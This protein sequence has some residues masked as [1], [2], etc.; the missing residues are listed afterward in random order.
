MTEFA[1]PGWPR[2]RRSLANAPFEGPREHWRA[3]TVPV[4]WVLADFGTGEPEWTVFHRGVRPSVRLCQVCGLPLRWTII[5]GSVP[6]GGDTRLTS[7][8]GCHPRCFALA[9]RNC[10]HLDEL[11]PESPVAFRYDGDG[12]GLGE[13]PW[14]ED[15]FISNVPLDPSAV[16]LARDESLRLAKTNPMGDREMA[17]PLA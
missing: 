16:P 13:V 10:P 11:P 14:V 17:G 15:E 9:L 5:L 12:T 3:R 4:P 2:P 8:P 7:G 6:S 1:P